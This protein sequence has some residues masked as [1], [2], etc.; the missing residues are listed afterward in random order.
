LNKTLPTVS[1]VMPAYNAQ[2]WIADTISSLLAQSFED[3]ELLIGD[4]GSTDDTKSIIESHMKKD[5]RIKLHA[6][7][8]GGVVR[9]RNMLLQASRGQYVMFHDADDL[10]VPE[11][12]HRQVQYL[13]EHANTV[14]VSCKISK[15]KGALVWPEA[16]DVSK[17]PQLRPRSSKLSSL[18]YHKKNFPFPA[19][20]VRTDVA[21]NIGGFRPYFSFAEDADFIY[22]LEEQGELA[23]LDETLFLYRQHASNTSK[24]APYLQTESSVLSR[25]FARR[26]RLG[27]P[28]A[29]QAWQPAFRRIFTS[30][31]TP[32]EIV[33]TL[34]VV[35]Y[36]YGWRKLK[37]AGQ[38]RG[39]EA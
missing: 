4:D 13:R 12:M 29:V 17:P 39:D 7:N 26:R 2:P 23:V 34:V 20:M 5:A 9:A 11:R 16:I 22:R 18:G 19:C 35:A 24:R 8:H 14:A 6:L 10:S 27:K 25:T 15:F 21:Q 37:N 1:V 3:F 28:D 31:L 33:Q 36:R 38:S 32:L 30:G